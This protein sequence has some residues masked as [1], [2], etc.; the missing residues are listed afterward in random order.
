MKNWVSKQ[1][2]KMIGDKARNWK[3]D[4]AGYRALHNWIAGKLGKADH[5]SF[6]STHESKRFTWANI[7]G[8][9]LRDINDWTQLCLKCHYAYDLILR[10]KSNQY[11]HWGL[12]K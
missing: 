8:S 6:D 9:Y 7:S 3:G 5:C 4:K 12:Y 1:N 2:K 11:S 10:G